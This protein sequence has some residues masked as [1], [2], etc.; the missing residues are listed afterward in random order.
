MA[1]LS[2]PQA[3]I[4]K[5]LEKNTT[6]EHE[7]AKKK[8]D[9]RAVN[10]LRNADILT[11]ATEDGKVVYR[12]TAVQEAT[13]AKAKPVK[14]PKEPKPPRAPSAAKL[15]GSACLCGCG[16][17]TASA[18]RRFLQGHDA[19]LHSIVLKVSRGKLEA[20]AY[21]GNEATMAYLKDGAPWMTG[22]IMNNFKAA[23]EGKLEIPVK[24]PRAKK[25]D[26]APEGEQAA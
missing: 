13:E 16:V 4:V 17:Q 5:F 11:M 7:Q 1:K 3:K 12:L 25:A 26:K 20:S 2:G 10:A 14:A 21:T 8:F 23:L 22:A 19:R 24:K 6:L 15:P 9:I 18:K